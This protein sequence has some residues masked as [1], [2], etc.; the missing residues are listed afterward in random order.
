LANIIRSF[1]IAFADVS[2]R[3]Q[4]VQDWGGSD[5]SPRLRA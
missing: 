1:F 4:I 3:D 5:D 2:I